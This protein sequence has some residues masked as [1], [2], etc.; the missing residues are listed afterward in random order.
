VLPGPEEAF[1]PMEK[2]HRYLVKLQ[3]YFKFYENTATF[4][5]FLGLS[6]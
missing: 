4:P 6:L 3:R 1:P 2:N 5:L